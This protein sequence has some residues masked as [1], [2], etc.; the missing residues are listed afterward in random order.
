MKQMVFRRVFF[1][2]KAS[3]KFLLDYFGGTVGRG[4]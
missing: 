3:M 4:K 1:I 2:E